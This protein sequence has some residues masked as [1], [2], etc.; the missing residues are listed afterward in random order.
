MAIVERA[1]SYTEMTP[2]GTGLRV[3]GTSAGLAKVH[4]KQKIPGR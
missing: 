1:A 4:R 2:S 3:I